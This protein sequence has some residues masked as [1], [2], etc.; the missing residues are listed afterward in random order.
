MPVTVYSGIFFSSF[1]TDA[2][3][4]F[5]Y[6][7]NI[8]II[9]AG[10]L[11]YSLCNYLFPKLAR[12][13][14]SGKGG[15]AETTADSLRIALAVVLPFVAAVL[16]LYREGT[17]VLYLRRNFSAE[18][19][20]LTAG[21]LRCMALG[22]PFF[23]VNELLSRAFYAE[24]KTFAPML[25]ALVGI[26]ANLA[27]S[28]LLVLIR[29]QEAHL[30]LAYA[31]G[32]AVSALTLFVCFVRE[33]RGVISAARRRSI[34]WIVASCLLALG[35]MAV[36]YRLYGNLPYEAGM[37]RNILCCAVVFLPGAVVYLAG[38]ALGRRLFHRDS[39]SER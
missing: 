31:L 6:A 33:N 5:D 25:A 13:K 9:L 4:V 37:P 24:K 36:V 18:A 28:V 30:G 19:A 14:S 21:L 23:A 26:A 20:D 29:G 11:T 39:V 38:L 27:S 12:L 10:T 16:V 2:V 3:S 22:M 17:A 8:Y 34:L 1:L 7:H 32:Q 35:T 15:F